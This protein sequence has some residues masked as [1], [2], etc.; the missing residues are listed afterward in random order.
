MRAAKDAQA[1]KTAVEAQ[2]AGSARSRRG[3]ARRR[4]RPDGIDAIRAEIALVRA[5][6]ERDAGRADRPRDRGGRRRRLEAMGRRGHVR[7][8][9][10]RG[11]QGGPD[12]RRPGRGDRAPRGRAGQE[13]R[14]ERG[15]GLE[16][17][18]HRGLR[19]S[20]SAWPPRRAVGRAPAPLEPRHEKAGAIK[21][22]PRHGFDDAA[23]PMAAVDLEGSSASSTR[24]LRNSSA[25]GARVR[26]GG[27]AVA[28][29]PQRLQGAA[30]QFEQ[31][32]RA[33]SSPPRCRAPT[34]TAR[35]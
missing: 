34:C 23:A 25:T 35:A 17:Q 32:P 22:E 4:E 33:R 16:G 21:R 12:L 20:C 6:S 19:R 5:E 24:R 7:A 14:A 18:R 26:Q 30:G 11:D 3:R 9:E 1:A 15:R 8:Q 28:A 10:P 13:G 27:L 29:R 2:G 31:L